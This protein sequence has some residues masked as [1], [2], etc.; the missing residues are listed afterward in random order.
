MFL[1][2]WAKTGGHLYNTEIIPQE[3]SDAEQAQQIPAGS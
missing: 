2:I 1:R 3:R